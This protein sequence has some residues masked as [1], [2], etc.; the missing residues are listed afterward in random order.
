[1]FKKITAFAVMAVL[2]FCFSAFGQSS[3]AVD[4]TAG[5]IK[6]GQLVPES[7]WQQEHTFYRDGKISKENLMALKGKLLLIDFWSSWCIPC[8]EMLPKVESLAAQFSK[9]FAVL[10]VNTQA[11]SVAGEVLSK[12][13]VGL[14]SVFSDRSIWSLFPHRLV[15]HY[16]WIG[17]DGRLLAT[18]SANE[19]TAENVSKYLDKGLL[20]VMKKVDRDPS[21]W[22]FTDTSENDMVV[23]RSILGKGRI[24]GMGSS[25]QLLDWNNGGRRM[26]ITNTSLESMYEMA[27]RGLDE[28]YDSKR[29]RLSMS[30]RSVFGFQGVDSSR[31]AWYAINSYSF[32]LMVR[33]ATDRQLYKHMLE[34]LNRATGFYG[35]LE[36][37]TEPCFVLRVT[38]RPL[39]ER[40]ATKDLGI[41]GRLVYQLNN[42]NLGKMVVD[43]TGHPYGIGEKLDP[44]MDIKTIRKKL[45]SYG[46]ELVSK[47]ASVN[48]FL[49]GDGGKEVNSVE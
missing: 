38:D 2:C 13:G 12:T 5:G 29:L 15:P 44:S 41:M 43:Q 27:F 7:F 49:V 37:R 33:P 4:I 19:V 48:Y 46:L 11:S 40:R 26:V 1:M 36:A 21:A 25:R 9:D 34:E 22:L 10:L 30:D 39:L 8:V 45:E 31:K 6:V 32:D 16:V 28:S 24:S 23:Y 20:T 35:R 17:K 42:L 18:T 14:A 47:K 3:K